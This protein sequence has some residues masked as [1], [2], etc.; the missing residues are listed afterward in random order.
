[1]KAWK[2]E[3]GG[4]EFAKEG[5]LKNKIFNLHRGKVSDLYIKQLGREE[6]IIG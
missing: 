3:S 2:L 5:S 6:E 4:P 1:L